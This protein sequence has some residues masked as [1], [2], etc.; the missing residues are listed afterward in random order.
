VLVIN[1]DKG[2]VTG[3]MHRRRGEAEIGGLIDGGKNFL[4]GIS[5][6]V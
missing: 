5:Q 1:V 4:L 3:R 2:K 6:Q